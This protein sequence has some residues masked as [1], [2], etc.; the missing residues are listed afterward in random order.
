MKTAAA[1][2]VLLAFVISAQRQGESQ[3][4]VGMGGHEAVSGIEAAGLKADPG[5]TSCESVL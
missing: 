3:F 2:S 1:T 5:E 4:L